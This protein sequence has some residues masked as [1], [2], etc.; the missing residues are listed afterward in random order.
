[1]AT[2]LLVM[3]QRGTTAVLC[4]AKLAALGST[5]ERRG[6]PT[7]KILCGGEA[8]PSADGRSSSCRLGKSL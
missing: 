7:L 3:E 2:G 6:R 8:L 5:L 4:H 1:M